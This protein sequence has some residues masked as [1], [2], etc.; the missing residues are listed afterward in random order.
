ME[1]TC[2]LDGRGEVWPVKRNISSSVGFF[3]I[4]VA[5]LFLAGFFLAVVFGAQTYRDIVMNQTENNQSR[6]LLS[7]LTTCAKANDIEGAV[8]I[9][10]EHDMPVLTI[11]GDDTGYCLRIYQHDGCLV[12][13]YGRA[14]SGLNPSAAQIIGETES[15]QVEEVAENTYFVTTDAGRV[16]FHVR[17]VVAVKKAEAVVDDQK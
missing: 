12:E 10:Y 16:L 1:K 11:T 8:E 13:D 6:A 17:S 5:G 2:G 14:D 7:Y 3:A 4:A 9:V 15:F